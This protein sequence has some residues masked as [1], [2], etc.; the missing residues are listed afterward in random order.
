[1]DKSPYP[2][3][4]IRSASMSDAE[5]VADIL[6]EAFST[7]PVMGWMYG[8]TQPQRVTFLELAMG[9]YLRQGF[10]HVAEGGAAALWLPAHVDVKLPLMGG[11]RMLFLSL[12]RSGGLGALKRGH[13]MEQAM[14]A[15]HPEAPHY[16][17]FAVGVRRKM[18]GRGLGG[19]IIREGLRRADEAGAPAYLENSNP[20]NTPLY[21]RL[22]FK[23]IA[24]LALP[25]GAPQLLGMMRPVGAPQ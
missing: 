19:R 15:G 20:K 16:Y 17:L 7:D 14:Q 1:M 2:L 25:A 5:E 18:T 9:V 12:L 21:E 11:L 10:G 22:G 23:T 13:V 24:P 6:A 4:E 3:P 8:N